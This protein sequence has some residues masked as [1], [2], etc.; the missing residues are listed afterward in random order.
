MYWYSLIHH[1]MTVKATIKSPRKTSALPAERRTRFRLSIGLVHCSSFMR[2]LHTKPSE[3]FFFNDSTYIH[4]NYIY[5][6]YIFFL[7]LIPFLRMSMFSFHRR[8]ERAVFI[9]GSWQRAAL[10]AAKWTGLRDSVVCR[11][12]H[13]WDPGHSVPLPSGASW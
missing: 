3:W 9:R 6:L 11:P 5:I 8:W 10:H 12:E 13:H 7:F 1:V 4:T 2:Y